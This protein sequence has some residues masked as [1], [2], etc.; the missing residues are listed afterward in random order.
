MTPIEHGNY[1]HIYN[2]GTNSNKIF[3]TKNDYHYFLKLT[4]IYI[5]CIAEIF[6]YALMGNHFH[7]LI[8]IKEEKEIGYLNPQKSKSKNLAEKWKTSNDLSNEEIELLGYTAKP[9]PEKMFQHLFST[10][11]IYFNKKSSGTGSLFQHPFRRINI[12]NEEYLKRLVLY[13]H[14]NPVKHNICNV[15]KH[16]QWTSYAS[17][18]SNKS[19]NLSREVL[20]D[21]FGGIENFKNVH[22]EYNS[23]EDVD[24]LTLEE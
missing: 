20:I 19:S 16:Y 4:A 6:A 8:R 13:I 3:T 11:A 5:D 12:E 23:F 7:F 2:R 9:N 22:E 1:Y 18:T 24:G 21:W 10:Y 15:L 14:H 17:M